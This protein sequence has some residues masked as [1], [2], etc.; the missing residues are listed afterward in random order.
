MNNLNFSIIISSKDDDDESGSITISQ[1]NKYSSY[2][3]N[4]LQPLIKTVPNLYEPETYGSTRLELIQR[5]YGFSVYEEFITFY[6]GQNS[7]Y[8]SSD[9]RRISFNL[10]WRDYTFVRWSTYDTN[11]NFIADLERIDKKNLSY[12]ERK[13]LVDNTPTCQIQFKDYDGEEV[14]AS[15][16][17][18][19]LEWHLGRRWCSWLKYFT[20]PLVRRSIN[21]TFNKETGSQK[22]SWKGGTIGAGQDM[23]NNESIL[24]AFS[25]YAIAHNFTDIKEL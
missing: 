6:Y 2:K 15:C 9:D 12:D 24:S 13:L 7:H 25:K 3:T 1:N 5:R 17:I 14:V 4:I 10:P 8:G 20:K 23:D 11:H 18:E 19:E 21:I 16:Y 22:G